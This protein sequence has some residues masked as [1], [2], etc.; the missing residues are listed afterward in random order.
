MIHRGDGAG[1]DVVMF[2]NTWVR[3]FPPHRFL[4]NSLFYKDDME[5][6][7]MESKCNV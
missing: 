7:F 4:I 3:M 2:G 6:H 5:L 1:Q